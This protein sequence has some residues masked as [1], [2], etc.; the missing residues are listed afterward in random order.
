LKWVSINEI[1]LDEIGFDS[2]RK[3]VEIYINS[4]K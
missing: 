3:V 2:L 1:N 4:L